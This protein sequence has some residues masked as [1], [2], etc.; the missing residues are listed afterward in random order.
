[1]VGLGI[2]SISLW[3][4]LGRGK[5]YKKCLEKRQEEM[6]ELA[7]KCRVNAEIAIMEQDLNNL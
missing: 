2:I 5:T 4:I 7:Y 1:M 3:F 6:K